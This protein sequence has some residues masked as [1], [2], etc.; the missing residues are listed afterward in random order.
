MNNIP[1]SLD[2][3][4]LNS[5]DLPTRTIRSA[6]VMNKVDMIHYFL[7]MTCVFSFLYDYTSFLFLFISMHIYIIRVFNLRHEKAH[8]PLK[9]LKG[10]NSWF[11]DLITFPY[12]PYQEPFIEKAK[13][14]IKHH[15]THLPH[16][17]KAYSE[18]N[19]PHSLLEQKNTLK[20]FLSCLFYE[21]VMFVIHIIN[22]RGLSKNRIMMLCYHLIIAPPLIYYFGFKK[23]LL[24][25]VSYRLNMCIAWFVFSHI[26]HTR[27]VY[28]SDFSRLFPHWVSVGVEMLLGSSGATAIMHHQYHHTHQNTFFNYY[29]NR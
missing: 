3:R 27:F 24:I 20:A 29:S 25:A 17:K 11:S 21:E 12:L 28:R 7:L 1:V 26:L 4:L 18:L 15:R 8:L 6:S 22:N 14:H 2:N 16:N 5:V 23:F 9:K 10:F 19:D 13:S